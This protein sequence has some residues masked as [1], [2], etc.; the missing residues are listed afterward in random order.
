M[1]LNQAIE[2]VQHYGEAHGS[3]DFQKTLSLLERDPEIEGRERRALR[4]VLR[5]EYYSELKTG[6][7]SA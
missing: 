1:T 3:T 7:D 4:L 5:S 2:F 6:T